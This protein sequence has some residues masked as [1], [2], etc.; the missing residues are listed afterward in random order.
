MEIEGQAQCTINMLISEAFSTVL[1][2]IEEGITDP[3]INRHGG[4]MSMR[5]VVEGFS[6]DLRI[7]LNEALI[8]VSQDGKLIYSN[9]PF[10]VED[11]ASAK[12]VI[13]RLNNELGSIYESGLLAHLHQ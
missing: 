13:S 10:R 9:Y 7:N 3:R 5:I 12:R 1:S 4:L 11:P 2:I 8:E 6:A